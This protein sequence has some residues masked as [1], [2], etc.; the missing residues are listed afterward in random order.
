[1]VFLNTEPIKTNLPEKNKSLEYLFTV[2]SKEDSKGYLQQ[3]PSIDEYV[4]TILKP[5]KDS[6]KRES[7]KKFILEKKDGATYSYAEEELKKSFLRS[8]ERGKEIGIVWSDAKF[9]FSKIDST[10]KQYGKEYAGELHFTCHGKSYILR[11]EC[12]KY[13]DDFFIGDVRT[14]YINTDAEKK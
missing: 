7:I 1:K 12:I 14:P 10:Q 9:Q 6:A 2:L 8:I 5:Y 4:T 3:I 13:R 11:T